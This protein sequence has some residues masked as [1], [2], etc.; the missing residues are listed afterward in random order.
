MCKTAVAAVAVS[1]TL[2]VCRLPNSMSAVKARNVDEGVFF[3]F[4]FFF[5][6]FPLSLLEMVRKTVSRVPRHTFWRSGP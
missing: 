3:L 2:T 6:F 4:C 5:I 1:F